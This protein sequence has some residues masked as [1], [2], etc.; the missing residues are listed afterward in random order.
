MIGDMWRIESEGNL[1]HRAASR[2]EAVAWLTSIF[3][4]PDEVAE[5]DGITFFT[6]VSGDC[7]ARIFELT[8][9]TREPA[10]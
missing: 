8:P 6:K 1:I 9:E 2:D 4:E 10:R 5:D 7:W 3:G